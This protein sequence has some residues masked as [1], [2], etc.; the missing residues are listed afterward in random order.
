MGSSDVAQ[1]ILQHP[2][3]N[4]SKDSNQI[5]RIACEYG[6]TE[7]VKQLLLDSRVDPS[8]YDNEAIIKAW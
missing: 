8:D 6:D 3:V 4:P 5:L 2:K 7:V 1:K